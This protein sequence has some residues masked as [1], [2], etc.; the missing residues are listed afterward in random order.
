MQPLSAQ[1]TNNTQQ[2]GRQIF[3]NLALLHWRQALQ[4]SAH[5]TT[6]T[7]YKFEMN[8]NSKFPSHW[9]TAWVFKITSMALDLNKP[10]D[11]GDEQ[12]LLDLND[13]IAEVEIHLG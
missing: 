5:T 2:P 7:L 6:T 12:A 9:I 4:I 8:L 10:V 3:W 1:Y 11:E 13:E